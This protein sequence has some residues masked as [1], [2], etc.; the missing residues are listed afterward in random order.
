[1]RQQPTGTTTI[2]PP[3][4]GSANVVVKR[5]PTQE[6]TDKVEHPQR[7]AIEGN[8][9]KGKAAAGRLAS[10]DN[11]AV[12]S[13]T[14]GPGSAFS[15]NQQGGITAGTIIGEA[16]PP[17]RKLSEKDAANLTLVAAQHPAKILILYIQRDEEAYHL[18]KQIGDALVAAGWRLHQPV[19]EAMMFSEGGGPLYGM[20]VDYRG[21]E[22]PAGSRVHLDL[23]T[24]SGV[25]TSELFR[26]FP[27]DF[28]AHPSP[29]AGDEI[30]L[31]VRT[32]PKSKRS[33]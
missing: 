3:T 33:Q 17:W 10:G 1:V 20:E 27:E 2:L 24:P 14:Q 22:V 25:S 18:A 9:N 4:T 19:T 28:A 13:I 23:T 16:P 8:H 29:K 5:A 6:V 12:G 30:V 31:S 15:I 11:S 26:L 21:D 32:N 7:S